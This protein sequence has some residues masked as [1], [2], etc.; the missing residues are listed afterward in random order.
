MLKD[1]FRGISA[2]CQNTARE[3]QMRQKQSKFASLKKGH[4][5]TI[6]ASQN[7][8]VVQGIER[9][10]LE[11]HLRVTKIQE[12]RSEKAGVERRARVRSQLY[13]RIEKRRIKTRMALASNM[14]SEQSVI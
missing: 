14:P 2:S 11:H 1:G 3:V 5:A 12:E 6:S 10:K 8:R 4:Q 7:A 13:K 9:A